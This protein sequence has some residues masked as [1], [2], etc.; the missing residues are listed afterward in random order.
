MIYFLTKQKS[1]PTE[2]TLEFQKHKVGLNTMK[3]CTEMPFSL[4]LAKLSQSIAQRIAS[5]IFTL[6]IVLFRNKYILK[7]LWAKLRQKSWLAIC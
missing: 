6:S 3:K 7:Q 4:S 2:K 1:Y 5:S